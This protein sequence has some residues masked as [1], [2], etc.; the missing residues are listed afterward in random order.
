[1]RSNRA[2]GLIFANMHDEAVRDLTSMRAFGSIPFGS[3]YRLV[4]FAL[5]NM[6]NAGI[7]KVGMIMKSNSQSLMDHIGSGK[8][9][10]LSRK[11]EGLFYL[12]PAAG[13]DSD[14]SGRIASLVEIGRFLRHSKEDYVVMSDCHMVGSIDIAAVVDAHIRTG[15]EITVGYRKG[16]APA[17]PGIPM[18]ETDGDGRITDIRLGTQAGAATGHGIGLYVIGRNLLMHLLDICVG[19]NYTNFERDVLQ[20]RLGELRIYGYEVPETLL[21]IYSMSSYFSAN[22][23]LL[24]ADV[25]AALF[26]AKQP[27]Y[28]KVRDCQPAL[29]GLH[30]QVQNSLIGEGASI[31]GTVRNSIIFRGVHIAKGAVVENCILMQ[32]T[33]VGANTRLSCVITDKN[34]VVR[35][36]RAMQGLDTYPSYIAKGALI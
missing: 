25:R 6:V 13:G 8:V 34:V 15:A 20:R 23:A 31:E 22:M 27:V 33:E 5:S 1:M 2:L 11:H 30:A 21:P 28:T 35:D 10:G 16:E 29:Y 32:G 17:L 3:R 7:V 26:P 19:Y 18:L 12:P 36:G 4:D 14:Y 24:D 9:W